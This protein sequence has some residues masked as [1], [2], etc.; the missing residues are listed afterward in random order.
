MTAAQLEEQQATMEDV[1]AWRYEQLLDAGYERC[2]AR[3]LARR[4][5]VDLHRAIELVENG[6]PDEL[7]FSILR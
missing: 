1:V 4:R 7:A 2:R 6:C 3:I 5:D